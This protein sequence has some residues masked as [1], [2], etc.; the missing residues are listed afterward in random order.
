[1][2]R[3]ILFILIVC[4]ILYFLAFGLTRNPRDLP[5]VMIGKKAPSFSLETMEGKKFTLE[6]IAGTPLVVNFWA[7]WCG[8]CFYEHP[9]L[10]KARDRYEKEGVK[11]LGVVYQDQ[12]ETV[13]QFLKEEGSPFLAL[14]DPE[15]KMAIDYGVGGVPETF[16]IDANGI[17][18][19]K[20]SGI[21]TTEY[22]N[23]QIERLTRK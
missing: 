18:Q 1:M 10:K 12:K 19:E 7:T 8:P 4:P 16:F 13:L 15:S 23:E 11:F 3:W 14:L 20:F 17:I 21:L 5:S 6:S 22:I 2:K 9:V